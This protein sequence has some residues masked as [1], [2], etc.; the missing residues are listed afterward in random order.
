MREQ[1]PEARAT[2]RL[3]SDQMA[4]ILGNRR[5]IQTTAVVDPNFLQVIPM[6]LTEG[7]PRTA[8]TQPDSVVI[9]Q[10]VARKFFGD[11]DPIGQTLTTG[12]ANCQPG[13]DTCHT[14]ACLSRS[15]A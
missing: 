9:S 14:P 2:T 6:P 11:A 12:N 4:M 13:S 5:F 15:R 8:L 3:V 1:I 10:S 7:D